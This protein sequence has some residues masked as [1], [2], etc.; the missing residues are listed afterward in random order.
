MTAEPSWTSFLQL[1]YRAD[2]HQLIGR[3]LRSVDEPE[4]HAGY[5]A[6]RAAARQHHCAH[7]LMDARRR[8]D[9]SRNTREWVTTDFLPR[10]QRELDL[11]LRVAFLVLPDHRR[12]AGTAGGGHALAYARFIEEGAANAWLAGNA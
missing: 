12:A 2:T 1:A 5:E 9:R 8:T 11:P 4:L 3:W 7:W 6:M 10:V